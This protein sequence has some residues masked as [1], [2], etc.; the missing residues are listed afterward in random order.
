[1]AR[2]DVPVS[3]PQLNWS[4]PNYLQTMTASVLRGTFIRKTKS[5]HIWHF[6]CYAIIAIQLK[7]DLM[8]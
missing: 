7:L 6:V 2:F 4:L 5:V 8:K 3:Y 1:M